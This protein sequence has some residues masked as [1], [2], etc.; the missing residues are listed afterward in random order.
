MRVIIIWLA[1]VVF[2][3]LDGCKQATIKKEYYP[4]GVLK[5]E[6]AFEKQKQNGICKRYYPNGNLE[7]KLEFIDD[8]ANGDFCKFENTGDSLVRGFYVQ[9][10]VVGPTYWYHKNKVVLYNESDFQGNAY[11]VIKYDSLDQKVI[12]EEGVA[13]S[14]DITL[15]KDKKSLNSNNVSFYYAEPDGYNNHL[16][17]VADGDTMFFLKNKVHLI[18]LKLSPKI[19]NHI[20]KIY[21]E[22]ESR[23]HVLISKDSLIRSW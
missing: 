11:Y 9:G 23:N 2:L 17:I 14:P 15:S 19:Q 3:I 4:N 1:L 6:T 20:I 7:E 22:F 5:S 13:V 21:S 12:K 10:A 8:Y 18:L 16:N